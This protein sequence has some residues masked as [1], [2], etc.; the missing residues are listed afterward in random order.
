M[1][2]KKGKVREGE[3]G[4]TKKGKVRKGDKREGKGKG[5]KVSE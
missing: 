4:V 5:R 3:K 2:E 1:T